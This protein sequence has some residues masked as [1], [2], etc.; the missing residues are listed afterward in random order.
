VPFVYLAFLG[1]YELLKHEKIE[2]ISKLMRKKI[3]KIKHDLLLSPF[4]FWQI[5]S[6]T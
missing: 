2:T 1:S 4:F 5:L 3:K 6:P